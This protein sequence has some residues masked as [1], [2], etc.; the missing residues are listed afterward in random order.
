MVTPLNGSIPADEMNVTKDRFTTGIHLNWEKSQPFL[1]KYKNKAKVD[2]LIPDPNTEVRINIFRPRVSANFA[3][4]SDPKSN[5]IA[6]ITDD[7][8]LSMLDPDFW[9]ISAA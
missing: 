9:N 3:E 1:T 5:A 2:K 6:N 7:T 8:C 4:Q